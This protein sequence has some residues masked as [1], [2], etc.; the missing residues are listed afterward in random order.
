MEGGGKRMTQQGKTTS[1]ASDEQELRGTF[2]S[3]LVIGI[4]ILLFGGVVFNI[5]N[6]EKFI[7]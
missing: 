5:Y 1:D 4:L 3:V 6:I 7:N 2:I